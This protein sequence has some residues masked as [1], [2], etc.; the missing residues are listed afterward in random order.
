[1]FEGN[2]ATETTH[3]SIAHVNSEAISDTMHRK[4]FTLFAASVVAVLSLKHDGHERHWWWDNL[5]H[6][7]GGFVLGMVSPRNERR[8]VVMV[9]VCW[10]AVEYVMSQSGVN[11]VVGLFPGGPRALGFDGWSVDHQIEDTMLDTVMARE[12]ARVA[13]HLKRR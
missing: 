6:F 9:S 4:I 10:E 11:E 1:V 7:L 2:W 3:F 5:N 12:G 8:T 13:Q